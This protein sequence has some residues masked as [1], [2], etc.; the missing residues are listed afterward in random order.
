M[1]KDSPQLAAD[2]GM[3]AEADA[4]AS[5]AVSAGAA[6]AEAA[7]FPAVAAVEDDQIKHLIKS[8]R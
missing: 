2:A 7:V 8:S 4:A 5:A 3:A 6:A 1:G